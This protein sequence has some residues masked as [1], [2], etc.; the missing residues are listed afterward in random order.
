MGGAYF[1]KEP[2][3]P[4]SEGWRLA[5][6]RSSCCAKPT[7]S[8]SAPPPPPC[9]PSTS[10]PSSARRHR[11][12]YGTLASSLT[13]NADQ[14]SAPHYPCPPRLS[15]TIAVV[16]H[17]NRTSAVPSVHNS[18]RLGRPNAGTCTLRRADPPPPPVLR[19]LFHRSHA[20]RSTAVHNSAME[21]KSKMCGNMRIRYFYPLPFPYTS[22]GQSATRTLLGQYIH[23]QTRFGSRRRGGGVGALDPGGRSSEPVMVV[24]GG[25]GL[26][27][28]R[29]SV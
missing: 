20:C 14:L 13:C 10:S 21:Q 12:C 27:R 25:G 17:S 3:A 18:G 6:C 4:V 28:I 1:S 15:C 19:K 11:I 16:S 2:P 29:F 5:L 23:L 8:A 22:T 24:G 7:A 9:P 26:L